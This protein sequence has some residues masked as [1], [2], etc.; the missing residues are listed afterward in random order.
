MSKGKTIR[1]QML[2][3]L[4]VI[5]FALLV[6]QFILIAQVLNLQWIQ[7]SRWRDEEKRMFRTVKIEAQRGEIRARDGR[8]LATSVPRYEIRLDFGSTSFNKKG[9]NQGVD[10]LAML[11]SELF[12]D[13]SKGAYLMEL[14]GVRYRKERYYLFKKGVTHPQWKAMK[15]FPVFREGKYKGGFITEMTYERVKPFGDLAAR[16][17]GYSTSDSIRRGVGIE[18]TYD[19]LLAGVEG[20]RLEQRL[21]GNFWKPVESALGIEPQ[22]GYDIETTIDINIQDVAHDALLRTLKKH[23]ARHGATVLME[24]NTGEILAISNLQRNSDGEYVE[25]YNFA[26]GERTEPG[27]TMKLASLMIALEDGY[28]N[29]NDEIDTGNGEYKIYDIK[30]K[31]SKEGGYGKLTIQGVFEHSSNVGVVKTIQ[32]FYSNKPKD[33]VEKLYRMRLNQ[34]TGI[35]IK[36]EPSPYIKYPGDKHWSGVSMYQMAYG[37]ELQLTPLQILNFYNA[38]ANDGKMVRPRLVRAI[39]HQGSLVKKF[40]TEVIDSRIASPKVIRQAHQMLEGVVEKGTAT[41]LKGKSFRIAG[42]TGTA[43]IANAKYGYE[44][45]S[46]VSYLASFVGYFPAEDPKYSCIVIVN[47]PSNSQYYGNAVAGPVFREIADKVYATRPEMI[48]PVESTALPVEER[49]PF[50]FSGSRDDLLTLF[51]IFDYP[52]QKMGVGNSPWIVTKKSE[53][54]IVTYNLTI[55][56]GRVPNVVGMGLRDAIAICENAGLRVQI[57]GYGMVQR[58][59]LAPN[60][61]FQKGETITLV[62][63]HNF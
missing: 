28:V 29:L 15:N 23:N 46:K 26:V 32:R 42:K 61:S 21:A 16:T 43:Q 57:E 38:V 45:N 22:A 17:I 9:F 54:S 33:F 11:L 6:F 40:H 19:S 25:S 27:S 37:Y 58:Q 5:F 52:V 10:S 60:T 53:S 3:R 12:Q 48:K 56:P 13:K 44:Y 47:E 35:D 51:D 14:Q 36:G 31:D 34:P 7:G 59:S 30:I 4:T 24:V 55:Y 2:N 8:T 1:E 62:L 41:N 63:T 20:R 39:Y 50:S 18:S 49:L